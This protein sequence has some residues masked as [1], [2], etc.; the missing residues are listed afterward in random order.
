MLFMPPKQTFLINIIKMLLS[1]NTIKYVYIEYELKGGGD[2]F[3]H[4]E[5]WI[6]LYTQRGIRIV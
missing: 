4:M 3:V 5:G 1:L 6:S 2:L